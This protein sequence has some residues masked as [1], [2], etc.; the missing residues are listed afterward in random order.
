MLPPYRSR[1]M[2]LEDDEIDIEDMQDMQDPEQPSVISR[3]GEGLD[4]MVV[5]HHW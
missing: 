5:G 2:S 4:L 3:A 1:N